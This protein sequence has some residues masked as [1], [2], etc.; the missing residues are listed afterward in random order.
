MLSASIWIATPIAII[1]LIS[2]QSYSAYNVFSRRRSLCGRLGPVSLRGVVSPLTCTHS[3]DVNAITDSK[4]V[5]AKKYDYQ[6]KKA[7]KKHIKEIS[8]LCV[9]TFLGDGDDWLHINR[10]KQNVARDLTK[11]LGGSYVSYLVNSLCRMRLTYLSPKC[12]NRRYKH[13]FLDSRGSSVGFNG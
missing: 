5:A 1:T 11:R 6:I 12:I 2:L 8:K 4:N 9:E 10:E 7:K 13:D 3:D